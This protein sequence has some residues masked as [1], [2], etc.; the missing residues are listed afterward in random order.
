MEGYNRALSEYDTYMRETPPCGMAECLVPE[1][2]L[3]AYCCLEFG[4][5]E[6]VLI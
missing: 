1:H 3:V 6:T 5:H 4:F 2:D